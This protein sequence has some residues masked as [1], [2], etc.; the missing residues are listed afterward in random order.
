MH[1]LTPD[2]G[3]QFGLGVFETIA[4]EGE[5]ALFL[6]SHLDRLESGLGALALS[7]PRYHREGVRAQLVAL[8]RGQQH[9]AIKILVTAENMWVQKRDNPYTEALYE[10][11]AHITMSPVLRNETSP[12]TYIKSCNYGDLY[13]EK[14]RTKALGYDEV[15]FTN[16]RGEVTEG[17][18]SNLFG[19]KQGQI[20]TPP[21]SCGLLNGVLRQFLMEKFPIREEIITPETLTHCDEV[22]LTNSLMGVLPVRGYRDRVY[23]MAQGA[24]IREAYCRQIASKD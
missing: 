10:K 18:V 15:I 8:A 14:Q 20:I 2:S 19:I 17:A 12:L 22:F 24:A 7:N 21:V 13:L 1:P 9:I 3:F 6:D 16:T 11:G 23:A 5:Q 4:V